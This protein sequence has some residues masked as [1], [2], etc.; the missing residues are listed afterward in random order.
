MKYEKIVVPL[1]GSSLAEKA[2]PHAEYL[3]WELKCKIALVRV[4]EP[5]PLTEH[6]FEEEMMKL[7]RIREV[8]LRHE[9]EEY[10]SAKAGALRKQGLDIKSEV[11]ISNNVAA[12]LL[13]FVERENA[14]LVI[15]TTYGHSG[16]SHLAYGRIAEKILRQANRAVLLVRVMETA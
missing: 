14:D 9:A 3:A 5:P 8:T 2:L 16:I 4:V 10:L 11:V 15:M 13:N 12:S 6:I 1:D 7:G